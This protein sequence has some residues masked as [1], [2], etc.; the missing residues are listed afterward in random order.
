MRI[1][2]LILLL[3][4]SI[5]FSEAQP[6]RLD[7][8]FGSK[9]IIKIDSALYFSL[10]MQGD[11]KILVAGTANSDFAMA[12]YTPAGIPD[13]SFSHDGFRITHF[14]SGVAT[15]SSIAVQPDGKI[16]VAGYASINGGQYDF[17]LARYN[18]D[19]SLDK[20]FSGNGRQVYNIGTA[21]TFAQAVAVQSDG[22]IIV[23]GYSYASAA[24][25]ANFTIARLNTDGSLDNTFSSD[26]RQTTDFDNNNDY[27]FSIAIQADGKIL[28][29]GYTGDNII[30][31]HN[32]FALARYNED[33]RPD[34][35]FGSNGKQTTDFGFGAN[36][37]AIAVQGD[38]K[39][40]VAGRVFNSTY[41]FALARYNVDGSPDNSFGDGGK[42]ITAIGGEASANAISI[43]SDGKIIIAGRFKK[44]DAPISA[45]ALA[46]Y[47]ADGSL[48]NTFS[49]GGIE[50]TSA[51]APESQV[52]AVA[53]RDDKLY[54]AG[55][56]KYGQFQNSVGIIAR[57]FLKSPAFP[58]VRIVNPA[59]KANYISPGPVLLT[60]D[61][62]E[63]D[64][65]I[66]S[67]D[68]YEGSNLLFTEYKAPYSRQ[69]YPVAT[70][71]YY[72]T[73]VATDN[74]GHKTTSA[75][76]H[77][78]VLH[79]KPPAV[80]ITRPADSA[81]YTT[82]ATILLSADAVAHGAKIKTVEFYSGATLLHT[83][84]NLPYEWNWKNV[85]AGSYR[86][87]AKATDTY[88]RT[89][90]SDTIT[91][92]V[93][94]APTAWKSASLSKKFK[95]GGFDAMSMNIGPNP[96][97]DILYIYTTGLQKNKSSQI[98]VVSASGVV[99]KTIWLSSPAQKIQLDIS[100]LASGL[101]IL[102]IAGAD[103]VMHE[104]FIK[105]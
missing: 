92:S 22:R 19:G 97:S 25:D 68:F 80:N 96:A 91:I 53:I 86:I 60:A 42:Q 3:L 90:T 17:A 2:I 21:Y 13:K 35:T 94:A 5:S 38:G 75:P 50:I 62:G 55:Y 49:K 82:P 61:A 77:I 24:G 69:W 105:L 93:T 15:A 1:F 46:R 58:V 67:V 81:V 36:G 101:Y 66:R 54:A 8:S 78:T 45:F 12:R 57:Y 103:G 56:A 27:I 40:V 20:T 41:D 6:G 18:T 9:G 63:F 87:S 71:S 52:A 88:G 83:E 43:Q 70:G 14:I 95:N 84:E 39:I 51:I 79:N 89:T 33:G 31:G 11:G 26:G 16:I 76:V 10:A 28:A 72:V 73:A 65:T 44:R 64:G 100:P 34:S 29:A 48:D 47:N 4:F 32:N 7:S 102:K 104:N 23:A 59:G 30:K 85:A 99:M 74:E 37:Y 98:S